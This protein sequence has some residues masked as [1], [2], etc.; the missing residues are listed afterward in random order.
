MQKHFPLQRMVM[1]VALC[2]KKR[3]NSVCVPGGTLARIG[4][5]ARPC[6]PRLQNLGAV[7]LAALAAARSS[8][9]P[10]HVRAQIVQ[11]VQSTPLSAV[12]YTECYTLVKEKLNDCNAMF[13]LLQQLHFC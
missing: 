6:A 5:N 13:C 1:V 9:H 8:M 3:C 10:I 12:E 2:P 7:A 11:L 4:A